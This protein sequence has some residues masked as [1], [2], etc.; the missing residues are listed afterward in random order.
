MEKKKVIE[1]YLEC[2]NDNGNSEHDIKINGVSIQQP[3]VISKI[4]KL[5]MLDEI[6]VNHVAENIHDN[7]LATV[8]SSIAE[9]GIYFS[10]KMAIKSGQKVRNIDVDVDNN[11]LNS[12]LIIIN[13][14]ERIAAHCVNKAY[15]DS[16]NL[17]E[18]EIKAR[19][20]MTT[21]LPVT[22]YSKKN[23][24]EFSNKFMNNEH[25][26][27]VHVGIINIKVTIV[28]EY[29]K[30]L[31]ESVPAT[32]A[33]QSMVIID[34]A[35]EELSESEKE[36]NNKVKRL[37][38]EL[39]DQLVL[40]KKNDSELTTEEKKHNERSKNILAKLDGKP[41]IDGDFFKNKR[42]LHVGIGEGTTE[43]PLTNDIVFDSN[44]INGSN[45]GIGHA[46]DKALPEF[47]DKLGLRVY[48]RQSYS[49]VLR[50]ANHK[51]HD[52]AME[53]VEQYI[54]EE[55]EDILPKVKREI[56]RANNDVDAVCVYGGGSILMKEYL[57]GKLQA[58]CDRGN[59]I[60]FYVTEE[61][62]VIIESEGM[63]EFTKSDIF[64]ALKSK[65]LELKEGKQ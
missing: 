56:E 50:D 4:R 1:Y 9:P 18:I 46:I 29:T 44:F 42:I 3:N 16:E 23:S 43:Y 60:L 45:N 63:Y 17:S 53:I 26:V 28:F 62:A 49:E 10:G 2:G 54:E 5:P 7:L 30:T 15:E 40:I 8:T 59:I 27:L 34:K 65:Y 51:Y 64:K 47:M 21:A 12:D 41:F 58:N 57:K 39:N 24:E 14:L 6:N 48:S 37:F 11:K 31:P 36:H 19:V 20:D 52:I 13:T 35:E 55:S 61:F 22:Q 33:L 25:I 32:F 38:K